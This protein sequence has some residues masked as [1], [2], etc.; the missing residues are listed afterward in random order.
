[1]KRCLSSLMT[2]TLMT[3]PLGETHA[4]WWDSRWSQ[5]V[6]HNK[7]C[8]TTK[9]HTT[10]R[11]NTTTLLVPSP[12]FMSAGLETALALLLS[13]FG[14]AL[15]MPA[16]SCLCALACIIKCTVGGAPASCINFMGCSLRC[17]QGA[18]RTIRLN[19]ACHPHSKRQAMR[20][21]RFNT[22]CHLQI[23]EERGLCLSR[24]RTVSSEPESCFQS[25]NTVR[26]LQRKAH[27]AYKELLELQVSLAL[28][29]DSCAMS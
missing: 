19:T 6:S 27:E 17:A 23:V 25:F 1:M 7:V 18:M 8:H 4:P 5:I 21:I 11:R 24:T 26:R 12:S 2:L 10:T 28:T 15:P 13:L 14:S 9:C 20:T 29:V 16:C 22:A 3:H